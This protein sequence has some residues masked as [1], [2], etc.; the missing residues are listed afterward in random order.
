M[1]NDAR[2]AEPLTLAAYRVQ[3]ALT[4]LRSV[5]EQT[6]RNES[7]TIRRLSIAITQVELGEAMIESIIQRRS[8]PGEEPAP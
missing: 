3:Q 4:G 5:R 2:H 7:T 8:G 6:P 1:S